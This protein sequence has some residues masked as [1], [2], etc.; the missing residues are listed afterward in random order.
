MG[1]IPL[2]LGLVANMN[3]LNFMYVY[4]IQVAGMKVFAI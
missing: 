4:Y 2:G 3:L 1:G